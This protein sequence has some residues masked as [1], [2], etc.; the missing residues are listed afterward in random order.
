MW[1]RTPSVLAG[2]PEQA[3]PLGRKL[4][5]HRAGLNKT[6]LRGSAARG[7]WAACI[8]NSIYNGPSGPPQ[9]DRVGARGGPTPKPIC[10][11]PPVLSSLGGFS[12]RIQA[13][14]EL[15]PSHRVT[16]LGGQ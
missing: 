3:S 9:S 10:P 1:G 13:P 11:Q 6:A 2:V 16:T 14:A 15:G 7:L 4:R 12:A 8:W 5:Y